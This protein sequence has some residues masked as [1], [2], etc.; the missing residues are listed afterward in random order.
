VQEKT[1]PVIATVL[2]FTPEETENLRSNW[3]IKSKSYSLSNVTI[4][5]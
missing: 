5:K 3:G 2:Q 4:E 1:L